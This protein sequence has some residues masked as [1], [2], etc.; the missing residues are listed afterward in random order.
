[1]LK[2][3][4]GGCG[5]MAV[6]QKYQLCATHN[7]YRLRGKPMEPIR[8]DRGPV[9]QIGPRISQECADELRQ[10]GSLAGAASLVLEAWARDRRERRLAMTDDAIRDWRRR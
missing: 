10:V 1:M 3:K 5:R 4:V 2:C 6:V 7:Q 8:E 9:I